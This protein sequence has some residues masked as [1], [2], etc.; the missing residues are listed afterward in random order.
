[1]RTRKL[2]EIVGSM[3]LCLSILVPGAARAADE[4]PSRPIRLICPYA[5][6]GLTDVLARLLAKRLSER[7]G[8]TVFVENRTG[9]GGIIGVDAVAK[10]APDG[11]TIVMVAQGL[12]SVNASL[13]KNL[14]YDTLRD[15][16]PISLVST[17][18]MVLVS[19]PDKP[20]KTLAE[21]ISMA[22]AKPGGLDYGSAG[23]ASTAHLMTELFNDQAGIDVLHVPFKGESVAFTELMGGRLT[24]MFATT[25]GALPHIQSGKLR[26]L[27]IATKERS[28]LLPNV[29]TVAE[30]GG[31]DFEVKGWY[32]ILAPVNVP[33]PV[34]E[35]LTKEFMA[36]AREPE[37]RDLMTSRGMDSV[38]STPEEFGKLIKSETE[39]WRKVVVKAGIKAD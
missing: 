22:K 8:Q 17:F 27:A 16:V 5:P 15:F 21:F 7:I 10:A 24:A 34:A 9:A 39:R 14:P 18:S 12:A 6:G 26:A 19:N 28:K 31:P 35:R 36:M 38:G 25:G 33:K 11:Y 23:N 20:P 4:Y 2:K 30:A 29:P 13:Y 1:M 3:L 32:G 37:M